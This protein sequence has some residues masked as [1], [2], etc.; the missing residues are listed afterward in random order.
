[1][2]GA[3]DAL[4][5]GSAPCI[6]LRF[7]GARSSL[8]SRSSL[9]ARCSRLRPHQRLALASQSP[10]YDAPGREADPCKQHATAGLAAMTRRPRVDV[11]ECPSLHSQSL[12]RPIRSERRP[13]L[14][15]CRSVIGCG[16]RSTAQSIGSARLCWRSKRTKQGA[17]VKRSCG[18]ASATA[19]EQKA[20]GRPPRPLRRDVRSDH[21]VRAAIH[22]DDRPRHVTRHVGDQ[23]HGHSRDVLRLCKAP[24]RDPRLR[25]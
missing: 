21:R 8:R 1:M 15:C 11:G 12:R 19:Q 13:F 5:C 20:N 24:E 6:A 22:R 14:R 17:D 4:R 23:E 18:P 7:D 2:S 25:A 16:D 10:A 3:P 9:R